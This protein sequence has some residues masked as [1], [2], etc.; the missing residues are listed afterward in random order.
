MFATWCLAC[1]QRWPRCTGSVY[2]AS[3]SDSSGVISHLPR[4][5]PSGIYLLAFKIG[6]C[7]ILRSVNVYF[8]LEPLSCRSSGLSSVCNSS[9]GQ[10]GLLLEYNSL[11]SLVDSP[12]SLLDSPV[13]C[14]CL[15]KW[16]LYLWITMRTYMLS[17]WII[18]F[19]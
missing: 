11:V 17:Q 15:S 19:S 7:T 6:H 4:S 3:R 13:T 10:S 14:F 1:L 12:V 16:K 5:Q 9:V 18:E 8:S 2:L